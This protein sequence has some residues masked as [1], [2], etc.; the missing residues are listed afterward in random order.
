MEKLI[1]LIL[2][3]VIS[4]S[5]FAQ[6]NVVWFQDIPIDGTKRE[7]RKELRARGYAY[8]RAGD[9]FKG[10]V[11]GQESKIIL[12]S[13]RRMVDAI[14]VVNN[15]EKSNLADAYN[16]KVE[17]FLNDEDYIFI[18]GGKI[19]QK[20]IDDYRMVAYP[21]FYHTVFH[22]KCYIEGTVDVDMESTKKN[23]VGISIGKLMD[24]YYLAVIYLQR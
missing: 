22:Q 19:N 24:C 2:G 16:S 15:I 5:L 17:Q 12:H 4:I 13:T 7:I 6:Q 18:A 8:N 21:E 9:Y 10:I 23:I 11:D 3:M 14:G 20:S 1:S